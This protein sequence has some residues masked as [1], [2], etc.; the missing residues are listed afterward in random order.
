MPRSLYAFFVL[1]F[2]FAACSQN[3]V[4]EDSSL[5]KYFDSAGV[6]GSF[7]LFD[8]GQGHFTIYN[9]PR[10][11]DSAYQPAATFDILQSLIALQTG[12]IKDDSSIVL[13]G[14]G[15]PPLAPKLNPQPL[16]LREAFNWPND[17]GFVEVARRIG[18]DTL[19]K[20]IDSLSY[21]T[22]YIAGESF[23]Y[24]NHLKITADEQLGLIKKLYFNQLPFFQRTQK[25][26]VDMMPSEGNANYRLYYK[27]GLGLKE[28]GHEIGWVLG[29]IEENK[30]PYFFVVS[31]ESTGQPGNPSTSPSA[32]TAANLPKTGL[33]I[34]RSILGKMGFFNGTK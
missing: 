25:M 17:S 23:W 9:L 34:T 31:L 13:S 10:F 22:K 11:R 15:Y 24:D 1:P 33:A 6:K 8:N 4:T 5:G 3:N 30:H 18:K 21:G 26:V 2:L 20:W 28:D 7:G 12:V 14:T 32:G 29:W 27:T 16:T 19:K